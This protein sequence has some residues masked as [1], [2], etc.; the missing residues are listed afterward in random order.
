MAER[1]DT[2]LTLARTLAQNSE[3][4]TELS[5][6]VT[7]H[8]TNADAA[9]ASALVNQNALV[10]STTALQT[11]LVSLAATQAQLLQVQSDHATQLVSL[12]LSVQNVVTALSDNDAAV[13]SSLVAIHQLVADNTANI[14]AL[15]SQ[16]S[17][18]VSLNSASIARSVRLDKWDGSARNR[19]NWFSG[20][21]ARFRQFDPRCELIATDPSLTFDC[22]PVTKKPKTDADGK[23]TAV[24]T[25]DDKKISAFI[26]DAI[27]SAVTDKARVVVNS[28]VEKGKDCD[29]GNGLV[30]W[31]ALEALGLE[32]VE[33]NR[34][35]FMNKRS[36]DGSDQH[37]HLI[38]MKDLKWNFL[39][40]LGEQERA[41]HS[42]SLADGLL[43]SLAPALRD[44]VKSAIA[45]IPNR[46]YELVE[47][48]AKQILSDD[49]AAAAGNRQR[50]AVGYSGEEHQDE[51]ADEFES[52]YARGRSFARGRG[53]RSYSRHSPAFGRQPPHSALPPA[54]RAPL[55][56]Q[57]PSA[58]QRSGCLMCGG[59][60]MAWGCPSF[61]CDQQPC[62]GRLAPGQHN[63]HCARHASNRAA[64]LAQRNR[65]AYSADTELLESADDYV[66][67]DPPPADVPQAH[68]AQ[69]PVHPF[70]DADSGSSHWP[71]NAQVDY[72]S[73]AGS[74]SS[75][76]DQQHTDDYDGGVPVFHDACADA[77]WLAPPA[78]GDV[79]D[80]FF[81][82]R[83]A[84]CVS[85]KTQ[86]RRDRRAAA[87]F[88]SPVVHPAP[89]H[90][91]LAGA[92]SAVRRVASAGVPGTPWS[93]EAPRR[94]PSDVPANERY[95][96]CSPRARTPAWPTFLLYTALLAALHVTCAVPAAA[97]PNTSA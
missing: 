7:V 16:T 30:A 75:S 50:R 72:A 69:A 84:W 43:A 13:A 41:A 81:D 27:S 83:D 38:D 67:G 44:Q 3:Q 55:A 12:S 36:A 95:P 94:A 33:A 42:R 79:P 11:S 40:S 68:S 31:Q 54:A 61:P 65:R 70:P 92:V 14:S 87:Y 91:R 29:T 19:A 28:A 45:A 32:A 2:T 86:R 17:S 77:A 18:L 74:W 21:R 46:T 23:R 62:N 52:N 9:S 76:F 71:L 93:F 8:V 25:A 63:Q 89:A 59:D 51:F 47:Q 73:A 5:R 6:L 58:A 22:D 49:E 37:Q 60:H 66:D 26:F 10:A 34:A 57:S 97:G 48:T 90:G 64:R 35:K 85:D 1:A 96:S 82:A 4:L 80:C 15:I 56:A 53:G 78:S 39:N 20:S 24:I 88:C